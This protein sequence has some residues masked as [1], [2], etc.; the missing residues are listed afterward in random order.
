MLELDLCDEQP[1]GTKIKVIGVGGAG[2]NAVNTMIENGLTGIEFV[3]INTDVSDLRKSQ[4]GDT[5]QIG[6][7]ATRGLGAGSNPEIGKKSAEESIDEIRAR[8]EGTDMIFIAAGMGGGTGTGAAPFIAE[9]A[10]DM[11]IL[12]IGIVNSPFEWEGK[13]RIMNA[14]RGISELKECVDSLMVIPNEKLLKTYQNLGFTEC[15]KK[16]D[17]ILYDAVKAISEIIHFSGYINVDFADVRTV[18]QRKGLAL[19]G[20]G[21]ASGEDRAQK[22]AEIAMSNP[23]LDDLTLDNTQG[24][25]LNIT[26]GNDFKMSEFQTISEIITNAT[27]DDGDI[28]P[29][30]V[31][32]ANMEG[33]IKVTFIATGLG[34]KS[35][36]NP[37]RPHR[38]M[39]FERSKNEELSETINRIRDTENM[40]ISRKQNNETNHKTKSTIQKEIPAF[41]R[42]FSN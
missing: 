32:D 16:A 34:S 39:N 9:I 22:A 19:M 5:L 17:N 41:M 2:G 33:K 4:A 31:T 18:M 28:I 14:E 6:K 40:N 7:E 21:V 25:L 29:G 11:D 13:K 38:G 15:F 35:L 10:K 30:V 36:S 20:I 24:V 12:S 27:G 23:L 1:F 26:A 8:L 42:K 37:I 3:V